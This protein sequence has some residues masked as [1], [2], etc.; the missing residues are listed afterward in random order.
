MWMGLTNAFTHLKSRYVALCVAELA[1]DLVQPM[2]RRVS[3]EL[4]L[5]SI[6]V[7]MVCVSPLVGVPRKGTGG[8]AV[9]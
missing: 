5:E 7:G 3:T 2:L 9:V 6:T 1:N 8:K 4:G